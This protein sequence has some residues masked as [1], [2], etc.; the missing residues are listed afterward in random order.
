MMDFLNELPKWPTVIVGGAIIVFV[1]HQIER[2]F[3][4]KRRAKLIGSMSG[5]CRLP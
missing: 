3:E 5:R 2:F 4:G 1:L